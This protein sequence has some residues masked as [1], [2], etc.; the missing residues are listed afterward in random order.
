M[1]VRTFKFSS[2]GIFT[3]EIDK[4]QL[5]SDSPFVG[6]VVIGRFERGVGNR[7][8]TVNSLDDFV[9]IYGDPI[10]GV[11]TEDPWREGFYSAPTY[12][13]Y[14]AKAY[15]RSNGPVTVIRLLGEEH[16]DVVADATKPRREAGWHLRS[17]DGSSSALS[18]TTSEGAYG[19]F[20]VNSGS[21]GHHATGT[22]AA[23][24]YVADAGAGNH[25][26][27]E[28]TDDSSTGMTGSALGKPILFNANSN[29]VVEV[30]GT[31]TAKKIDFNFDLTSDR[32]IRK[33]FNTD[34]AKVNSEI[35]DTDS[36][37]KYWLGETYED[38]VAEKIDG[39]GKTIAIL[40]G[41][42]NEDTAAQEQADHQMANQEAS[43]PW[44]VSQYYGDKG[45]FSEFDNGVD[46]LFRL[47]SLNGGSWPSSNL[48][49]SITD[50]KMSKNTLESYPTFTVIIR[51]MFD[52][53]FKPE[54]I[55]RYTNCNLNPESPNY[56]AKLIGDQYL[57]WSE[58]DK[59]YN[60]LGEYPNISRHFRVEVETKGAAAVG[61]VPFGFYGPPKYNGFTMASGSST[62]EVLKDVTNTT[63]LNVT[64]SFI[65]NKTS[66]YTGSV[67][68]QADK[69]NGDANPYFDIRDV[70]LPFTAS[71]DF[72][73]MTLR[74][75]SKDI[76]P[77]KPENTYWGIVTTMSGTKNR[78][79]YSMIDLARAS[80]N[81]VGGDLKSV[82]DSK[83][84]DYSFYFTLDNVSASSGIT[85]GIQHW[86]YK[87]DSANDS[88]HTFHS[89]TIQAIR[90][91]INKFTVPVI[92]GFDGLDIQEKEPYGQH[93]I[94]AGEDNELESS[95]FYT[96]NRA[97]D[98]VSD[99]E[100][101][102]MNLLAMPGIINTTLTDR[103]IDVCENRADAL[104][105]VDLEGGYV[106]RS[107]R[108]TSESAG[109]NLG[110]VTDTV[111]KLQARSIN[112]SYACAYYPWVKI[113]DRLNGASVWVPP[114]VIAL[115]T[116]ANSEA[117]SE[118][119]FAPAGFNR[120]GLSNGA[121]GL[122]VTGV[123]QKL[124][125]KDR[126]E[127]YE[128][129]INPIASFPAE[130]IVV[131]GQK[132]LQVTPSALDRINVRRLMIFVKREISLMARDV[133]FDQNVQATWQRFLRKVEPF[134][135]NV[136]IRFGLS[137]FL[138]VL[139]ETTTTPD[140]VDRNILY[141]KI[142]L[143]PARAIEFIA[144]DFV[145][146]N[147]GADFLA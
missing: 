31:T 94:G 81:D 48:K 30:P 18:P 69:F 45:A 114:S 55:E 119:W 58:K 36:L 143:K 24:F 51:R 5:F 65:A 28:S 78:R 130:G 113:S 42:K 29:Y 27:L 33:V 87:T 23:I 43:T 56:I 75:K 52:S 108:K 137:D 115:G 67:H 109:T 66:F 59:A 4:T 44:I 25:L 95:A 60:Q 35:Y 121:A 83:L 54:I 146:T 20:L 57:E 138:V 145:L 103:M 124:K 100:D 8:V 39:T 73:S 102:E 6:P 71:F 106:P 2:P 77:S 37:E 49:V 13:A 38:A 140:L 11:G 90:D 61:K 134:L 80:A 125:A 107:D 135:T 82:P 40:L 63:A 47:V 88:S 34:P 99:P 141:A 131:F 7:P 50:L 110:S 16:P 1:S 26:A 129:N 3:N 97:L 93:V 41:L 17:D 9:E 10:P 19:L 101:V 112:S 133:L 123:R 144:L 53:D 76:N 118:L 64:A 126:D 132:T 147:T 96:L 86:E 70:M 32:Y 79:N 91:G 111:N 122:T 15:L 68:G 89:G 116:M 120:G 128:N 142:F 127:L 14:A 74:A 46:K 105:I 85:N 84:Q 21:D 12:A 22:L 92:G 98:V 139:D 117:T 62:A 136:K 72:P 104:A